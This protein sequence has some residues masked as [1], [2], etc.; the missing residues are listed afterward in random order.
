MPDIEAKGQICVYKPNVPNSEW[1][2]QQ[3]SMRLINQYALISEMCLITKNT[4]YSSTAV[5]A[6]LSMLCIS[7]RSRVTITMY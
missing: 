7:T 2:G 5:I 4:V 3:N 6:V 1:L